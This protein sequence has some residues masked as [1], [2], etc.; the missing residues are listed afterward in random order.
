M[1]IVRNAL[2]NVTRNKGR[3][4]LMIIIVAIITAAATIGLAIVQAAQ[5]A[6]TSALAN[7]TIT[8]QITQ[9]RDAIMAKARSQ[10]DSTSSSDTS[11]NMQALRDAMNQQLTLDQYQTYDKSSYGVASSYYTLTSSV[12]AVDGNIEPVSSSSSSSSQQSSKDSSSQ[13]SNNNSDDANRDKDPQDGGGMMMTT[14]DFSLV[15]FSSDE[16]LANASNGTFTMDSGQAFGYGSDDINQ[17]IISKT[18]AQANN[19]KVGDTIKVA[20]AANSKTV[21]SFKIVG[22]YSNTSDSSMPQGGPMASNASDPDNAIYTSV[23]TMNKLGLTQDK[24]MEVTDSRGNTRSTSAAQLTYTYVFDG[25]QAYDKFVSDVKTAGLSDEYT[26]QS[27]DVEQY[28]ASLVPINNVANFARTLLIIVLTVGALVLIVLTIFNIRERKYEIGVLTA[29]G[30]HKSKVAMQFVIELL[31]VTL[32]GV[33]VG[34]GIGAATSVPVSNALLSSQVQA[35]QEQRDQQRAQ[36]GRDMQA[37]PDA[38]NQSDTSSSDTN[39][40]QDTQDKTVDA[41]RDNQ[42]R[43]RV[44]NAVSQLQASVN[45]VTLGWILLIG[46]GLTL[47]ASLVAA[48]FVMRYE[49]LQ[50]LADRS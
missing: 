7:T 12:A 24:T 19:L 42:N 16:A 29:I 25:K 44:S 14:G 41:P 15:G 22:I 49:P 5:H 8:A 13:E 32:L 45:W 38:Q 3:N 18:L 23:A 11:Q 28:E 10:A 26:V 27:A 40:T 2:R 47:L 6:R 1:F 48:V 30:I 4:A 9:D 46:L 37:P 43:G 50:I 20:N 39:T 35:Q 21:Y 36:F 31:V 17:V 33:A 34:T